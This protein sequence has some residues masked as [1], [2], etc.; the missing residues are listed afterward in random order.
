MN[1]MKLQ[2]KRGKA[3]EGALA[4]VDGAPPRK[5]RRSPV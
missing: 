3:A 1:D 2:W 5:R 4:A